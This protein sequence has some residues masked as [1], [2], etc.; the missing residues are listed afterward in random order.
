M[1]VAVVVVATAITV[2]VGVPDVVSVGGCDRTNSHSLRTHQYQ[3]YTAD[4]CN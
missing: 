4:H 1:V 2:V 3:I